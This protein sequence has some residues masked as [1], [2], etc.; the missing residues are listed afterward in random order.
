[1]VLLYSLIVMF[2]N[3]ENCNIQQL[4]G[5]AGAEYTSWYSICSAWEVG[6]A[7]E[8]Q[9]PSQKFW[10]PKYYNIVMKM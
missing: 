3:P 9:Y 8:F 5:L 7:G 6:E 10:V 4:F 1:M 2:C